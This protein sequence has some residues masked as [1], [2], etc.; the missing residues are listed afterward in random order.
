MGY[1]QIVTLLL[2]K[3]VAITV[4]NINLYKTGYAIP[5][6]VL[7]L[8]KPCFGCIMQIIVSIYRTGARVSANSNDNNLN[9]FQLN[10]MLRNATC[11]VFVKSFTGRYIWVNQVYADQHHR[12]A[13]KVIGKTTKDLFDLETAQK[14]DHYARE[15]ET[16]CTAQQSVDSLFFD[17]GVLTYVT[18]RIPLLDIDGKISAYCGFA[19]DISPE[20][21]DHDQLTW[22]KRFLRQVIDTDP[23]LIFVKDIHSRFILVNKAM[24]SL[25]EREPEQMVGLRDEELVK[26]SKELDKYLAEDRRVIEDG[27]PR[28]KHEEYFTLS[29]GEIRCFQTIKVPLTAPDGII[30]HVLGVG[31]DITDRNAAERKL[32]EQEKQLRLLTDNT[33]DM[34]SQHT[35][36]GEFLYASRAAEQL[37]GYSAEELLGTTPLEGIHP[38]DQSTVQMAFKQTIKN[39]EC[40]PFCFRVKTKQ[41]RYKWLEC[42]TRLAA[43]T[44][45]TAKASIIAV[46]RDIDERKQSEESRALLASIVQ[47]SSDA[48]IAKQLDG[49][50]TMWNPG[51]EKLYGYTAD[52][53]IGRNISKIIPPS[54]YKELENILAAVSRGETVNHFETRRVKI[55][56]STVDISLAVSPL[57]NDKGTV[58]GASAIGHDITARKQAM[59]MQREMDERYRTVIETIA[60][61]IMLILADGT[62]QAVNQSAAT[63]LKVPREQILNSKLDQ[64]PTKA[65]HED[66]KPF[67]PE[68]F[69]VDRSLQSGQPVSNEVMVV[70]PVDNNDDLTWISI[71]TKPLFR[72]GE[73]TP[74]AVVTSFSDITDRK[75]WENELERRSITDPLTGIFNRLKL[76]RELE[77]QLINRRKNDSI[78]LIMFDL[79]HFKK[80][81]DTWGHDVGDDVLIKLVNIINAIIRQTDTFARWGGEEFLI[82]CPGSNLS[83]AKQLAER[84]RVE[85]EKGG[86]E[87][88]PRVTCS[89]GVAAIGKDEDQ[90]HFLKR[91]DE[92][93]Y[94]AKNAGRNTVK[95]SVLE[96]Q[97]RQN[98]G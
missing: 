54:R 27:K 26:E 33:N 25:Y 66:G 6:T 91:A 61:G 74:Y 7:N 80:V 94:E 14:L 75:K 78:S 93:L 58:I 20:I 43:P 36:K 8:H 82:L 95:W 52:Q 55:D 28:I 24:A 16:T 60:E 37:I 59:A 49:T 64:L 70:Q 11:A 63:I 18:V 97:T 57:F 15:I 30:K 34:I 5:D 62:I 85:V 22:Q 12:P 88:V 44:N 21:L 71:N 48:I 46:S 56:G 1:G 72:P 98:N 4:Y 96:E 87:P 2:N 47:S 68:Q 17:G 40:R 23:N 90:D 65:L 73:A 38:E 29:N 35:M 89:F 76:Q 77:Y 42:A 84:M 13:E 41:N 51:A 79:D 9:R 92:A 86:F 19:L 81:N 69:P 31:T 10:S 53:M 39:E 3:P 50:I 83:G 45:R 67:D 32:E